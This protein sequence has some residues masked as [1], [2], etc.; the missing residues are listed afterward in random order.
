MK[1]ATSPITKPAVPHSAQ[2]NLNKL[3]TSSTKS[4]SSQKSNFNTPV[5]NAG[6]KH[7]SG[8]GN[9][10]SSVKRPSSDDF[11]LDLSVKKSKSFDDSVSERKKLFFEKFRTSHDEPLLR[12]D[13]SVK[14]PPPRSSGTFSTLQAQN[15][16][17]TGCL[18]SINSKKNSQASLASTSR[19]TTSS[20]P[21]DVM[22]P[23]TADYLYGK[24]KFNRA[25]KM[26]RRNGELSADPTP[27]R[28]RDSKPQSNDVAA[29]FVKLSSQLRDSHLPMRK[30]FQIE[31]M[32]AEIKRTRCSNA[33]SASH[34]PSKQRF[35]HTPPRV[36]PDLNDE[37]RL[38]RHKE[39]LSDPH[40][41]EKLAPHSGVV[42]ASKRSRTC[43]SVSA[44]IEIK[45]RGR[46]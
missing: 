27:E 18:I 21:N 1:Q 2:S 8:V 17:D 6:A 26:K 3:L 20:K 10:R 25:N 30:D 46:S 29:P 5:E 23:T 11:P 39:E 34:L 9:Y 13:F 36:S 14:A 19:G 31:Q 22:K 44:R 15:S 38:L 37:N 32:L 12:S 16:V 40:R 4:L 33:V 24:F 45:R 43:S 41:L 28:S 35:H 7:P 42:E